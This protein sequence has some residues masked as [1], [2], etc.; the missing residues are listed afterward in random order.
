MTTSMQPGWYDDPED[1]NGQRYWDGQAWTPHRQGK[2]VSQPSPPPPP[3]QAPPPSAFPPP[4]PGQQAQWAPPPGAPPRRSLN[5]LWIVAGVF[6]VLAIAVAV[7][8]FVFLD[9]TVI[10]PDKTA[11]FITSHVSE[12]T[13]YTP[14]DVKCPDGVELKVG[15]TLD[16]HFTGPDGSYTVHMNVTKVMGDDAEFDWSS[17]RNE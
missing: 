9:K 1:S 3:Q 13:G 11:R 16:C 7:V 8:F 6:A 17:Q 2:P 12:R 14:T 15:A 10:D 5:P 4:P